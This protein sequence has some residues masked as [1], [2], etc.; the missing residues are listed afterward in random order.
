MI[1]EGR[2]SGSIDQIDG[3][4]HFES[5]QSSDHLQLDKSSSLDCVISQLFGVDFAAGSFALIP[6][7]WL[8]CFG[9]M[10][11]SQVRQKKRLIFFS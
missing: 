11:K 5:K 9:S 1:S 2:M 6:W 8:V 10:R 4:V 3:V 7:C